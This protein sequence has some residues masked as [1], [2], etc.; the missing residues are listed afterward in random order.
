[1]K[2]LISSVSLVLA[3]LLSSG[4]CSTASAQR[5]YRHVPSHHYSHHSRTDNILRG[6]D[7]V[8]TAAQYAMIG[9]M[10]AKIDDYTGI[11]VGY[12]SA[13]LRVSDFDAVKDPIHGVN[14][15]IVFG[16]YLGHSCVAIEP[17]FYYSM[18][19]GKLREY[20]TTGHHSGYDAYDTKLTMHSFE[21]PLNFKAHLHVAPGT[22][23][24]PFAGPFISFGFAGTA[25]FDGEK[26]DTF[27]DGVLE[28]FDAGLR[29][30]SGLQLGRIYFEAAYDLGLLNLCDRYTFDH[31]EALRSRTWSF[32]IGYNF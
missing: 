9:S 24:Q 3:L 16:W 6:L 21:I 11:R 13:T 31:S 32:S 18:K 7:A 19:G 10:L 12:N 30:G 29:F 26:Y 25:T 27:D 1:M 20:M 2:R 15:G 5:A 28:D 22:W 14:L 23:L 4:L 17:G 8:E